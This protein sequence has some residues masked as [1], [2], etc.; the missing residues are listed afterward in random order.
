MMRNINGKKRSIKKQY[1]VAAA[2]CILSGAMLAG[3]YSYEWNRSHSD[4]YVVDLTDIEEPEKEIAEIDSKTVESQSAK[5]ENFTNEDIFGWDNVMDAT[6]EVKAE[7]DSADRIIVEDVTGQTDD[8]QELE[9]AEAITQPVTL[10]FAEGDILNWPLTGNVIMNY[11]MDK[12]VYFATLNQYKYNPAIIIAA[13]ENTPVTA[14]RKGQV[15]NIEE[16]AETG[17]TMIMDLGNDYKATYGQLKDVVVSAGQV[18]EAGDV[19]GYVSAPTK[20][21]SVEG[22]NL[23][24]KLQQGSA[25]VNPMSY[26]Q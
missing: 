15:V 3:I 11:S 10:S 7:E 13:E 23:Y 4:G 19:I 8:E 18:V 25:A 9:V 22:S 1:L 2:V 14:V 16:T 20:Y 21:Y 6:D 5:A 12:S 17:T 24:F 26:L